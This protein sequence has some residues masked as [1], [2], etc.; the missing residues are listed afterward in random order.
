MKQHTATAMRAVKRFD[1]WLFLASAVL[2][3]L[4]MVC[5]VSAYKLS[6]ER[7]HTPYAG[8]AVG[9]TVHVGGSGLTVTKVEHKPGSQPFIAPEGYDY[10]IVTLRVENRSEQPFSIA[11]TN[12]TYVKTADGTVSYLA[13]FAL[14]KPFHS[15]I[16][17]PGESTTGELSYLMPKTGSYKFYVESSWTST[18]VPFMVKSEDN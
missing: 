2:F 3:V 12:D 8:L 5:L 16:V 11:P 14:E 10:L 7:T 1:R 13:P 15:G 6:H 18:A 4:S 9:K 17:L